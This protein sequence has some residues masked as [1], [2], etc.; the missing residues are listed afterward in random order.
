MCSRLGHIPLVGFQHFFYD[1]FFNIEY[2]SLN[3]DSIEITWV[4]YDPELYNNWA[5]KACAGGIYHGTVGEELIFDGS[6]TS[7]PEE[8][9]TDYLW[10]F[11]DGTQENSLTQIH[12]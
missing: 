12:S 5:P 1:G 6:E 11:G 10:D 8:D 4:D 2:G 7:D 3:I 9:I